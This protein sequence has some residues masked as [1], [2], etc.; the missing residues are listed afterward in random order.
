MSAGLVRNTACVPY[1]D[2]EGVFTKPLTSTELEKDPCCERNLTPYERLYVHHTLASARKFAHFKPFE[3]LIPKDDLDFILN[4][5]FDESS[6]LFPNKIDIYIQPE[7]QGVLTWRRLRNTRDV[8]PDREQRASCLI[9]ENANTLSSSDQEVQSKRK[10][11]YRYNFAHKLLIGGIAE[12]KHP[13][14]VKL[15]N[16]SHHSPQT[17]AGY[18]RQPADG[19]FYQY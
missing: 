13:S 9:H 10:I 6:D 7:T 3:N 17:N 4:S 8:T 11:P 18:S 2:S 19:N 15:M 5:T 12:K 14:S 16:S 1:L